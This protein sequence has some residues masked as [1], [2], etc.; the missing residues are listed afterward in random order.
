MFYMPVKPFEL[1]CIELNCREREREFASV[2]KEKSEQDNVASM[3]P[4]RPKNQA[5]SVK[6]VEVK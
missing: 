2:T 3:Q 6:T 1:N 5:D 4:L